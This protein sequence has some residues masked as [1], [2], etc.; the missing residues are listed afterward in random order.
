MKTP[1][2]QCLWF[3][4]LANEAATFYC[5][6]FKNSKIVTE[7]PVAT[8]FELNGIQILGL[9]GGPMFQITSSISYTVNCD[10]TA[11]T[12]RMWDALIEDMHTMMEIDKIKTE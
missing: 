11:E 4:N 3:D 1:I 8:S 7:T 10:P 9:N 2:Y 6:I 5:S 12:N